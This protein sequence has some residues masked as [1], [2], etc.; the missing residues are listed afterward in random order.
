[1]SKRDITTHILEQYDKQLP[2][3][4]DFKNREVEL[5]NSL[6]IKSG[7]TVHSLNGKVKKREHLLDSFTSMEK[8]PQELFKVDG[9]LTIHI[10]VYFEDDV[11]RIDEIINSE[12]NIVHTHLI[13]QRSIMDP[14]RFGYAARHY[15]TEPP[16]RRIKL[17]EYQ[18]FIGMKTQVRL[19]SVIQN[20][21]AEILD[22]L[23]NP[24]KDSLPKDG[25]RAFARMAGFLELA[26]EQL[27]DI[28]TFIMPATQQNSPGSAAVHVERNEPEP[29]A[30]ARSPNINS[31]E[32]YKAQ[33][34]VP[35]FS[36]Q[37]PKKSQ[38]TR[39]ELANFIVTNPAINFMDRQVKDIYSS[40]LQYQELVVDRLLESVSYFQFSSIAQLSE[41]VERYQ[42]VSLKMTTQIFGDP[43][44][45]NYEFL[46]VG[47]SISLLFFAL[48]AS[49]GR[50]E[51]IAQYTHN[52]SF[53]N[54]EA[55]I[56][57]EN[58]L[59]SWYRNALG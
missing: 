11:K 1:M 22:H 9:L 47:I 54:D 28:K 26:D 20:A 38:I 50:Q 31:T 35:A 25:R 18:Q 46:P 8:P 5:L 24:N 58:N 49:T 48:I 16:E 45:E 19:F 39:E 37:E 42:K 15:L 43:E 53:L 3:L 34:E 2:Y 36:N 41:E 10:I 4:T 27:N 44:Q 23:G 14:D 13:D 21:W 6:I 55:N 56:E 32:P 33:Y 12:F 30:K 59:S 7:I 57:V 52:Y 40:S 17:A 51:Q 29:R